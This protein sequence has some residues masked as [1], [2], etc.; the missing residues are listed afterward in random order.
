VSSGEQLRQVRDIVLALP[1]VNERMSHGALCFFV[2]NQR[3]LCYFDD[4][5]R[6]DGRISL[7]CPVREGAQRELTAAD[8][9][10]FFAPT[11]SARGAFA[12]WVGVFL[13]PSDP[14]D[15]DWGEIAAILQDAYRLVAP[16]GLI[17]RLAP[18]R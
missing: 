15:I 7:W 2:Q 5:H 8:P 18:P 13:D 12:N 1:D 17:A 11:T 14:A 16:A 10:R 3:A 9:E 4:D 6:G